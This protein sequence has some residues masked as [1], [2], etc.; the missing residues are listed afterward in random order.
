MLLYQNKVNELTWPQKGVPIA[1]A[2]LSIHTHEEA[3]LKPP[4][5]KWDDMPRIRENI[6][7]HWMGYIPI[8]KFLSC[9]LQADTFIITK[10]I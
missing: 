7:K 6:F 3:A 10:L 9:F 8:W 5:Q 4:I 2:E 1:M